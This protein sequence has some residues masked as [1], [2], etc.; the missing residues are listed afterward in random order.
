[1]LAVEVIGTGSIP[2][3]THGTLRIHGSENSLVRENS[4]QRDKVSP[5]WFAHGYTGKSKKW[6]KGTLLCLASPGLR[7][8]C[9]SMAQPELFTRW[10]ADPRGSDPFHPRI[11]L[12]PLSSGLCFLSPELC[13]GSEFGGGGWGWGGGGGEE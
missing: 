1:M 9:P 10:M 6:P 3:C 12:T 5:T 13:C 2:P 7:S 8:S 11:A 4:L